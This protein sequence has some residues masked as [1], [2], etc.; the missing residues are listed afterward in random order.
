MNGSH[1]C[2]AMTAPLISFV[3]VISQVFLRLK[4]FLLVGGVRGRSIKNAQNACHSVVLPQLLLTVPRID[5]QPFIILKGVFKACYF[6]D[7]LL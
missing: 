4:L 7:S 3:V 6:P 2:L 1:Y 5:Y